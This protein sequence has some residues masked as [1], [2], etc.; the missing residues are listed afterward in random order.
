[1]LC[2]GLDGRLMNA[3]HGTGWYASRSSPH[4]RAPRN[5]HVPVPAGDRSAPG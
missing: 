5:R 4:Q 1:M 2:R 3:S